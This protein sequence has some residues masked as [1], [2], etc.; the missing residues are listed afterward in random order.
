MD[1][2]FE[3]QQSSFYAIT[4]DI[5]LIVFENLNKIIKDKWKNKMREY[6]S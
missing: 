4:K 2:K 6:Q 1:E 3:N 5:F